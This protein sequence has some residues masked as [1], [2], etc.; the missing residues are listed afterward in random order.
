MKILTKK[1]LKNLPKIY[2]TGETHTE[3][4][5][6]WVKFFGGSSY[7]YLVAEFDPNERLLFGFGGCPEPEWGYSSLDELLAARFPPF[8]LP[9][10]RDMHWTP[11]KF[12]ECKGEFV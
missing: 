11:K 3:D 4:K 5:I 12:S 10:E 9:M 8:G 6:I 7:T 1:D 2:A